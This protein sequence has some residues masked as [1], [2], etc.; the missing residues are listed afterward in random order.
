MS[1]PRL[2]RAAD[3]LG[4]CIAVPVL[5]VIAPVLLAAGF[6]ALALV[7]AWEVLKLL[8]WTV[9]L[10]ILGAFG[11]AVGYGVTSRTLS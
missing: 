5:V 10:A 8:C 6:T 11:V 7:V 2:Q 3:I 4:W 1:P 9:P